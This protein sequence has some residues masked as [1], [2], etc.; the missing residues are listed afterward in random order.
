MLLVQLKSGQ[1]PTH[2][3]KILE[4]VAAGQSSEPWWAT[5]P[6]RNAAEASSAVVAEERLP[7]VHEELR[8]GTREVVRGGARV[9]TRVQE[10]PVIEELN[11]IEEFLRA[12]RRPANRLVSQEELDQ[13][14]LLRERVIEVAQFREE[15]VISKEAF[16]REEVVV[17]KTIQRRV[18]QIHET[19]R[20]T[21]VD[22]QE[23]NGDP[24]S[25]RRN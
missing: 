16:V 25:E 5:Q 19:V 12:E 17:S 6:V 11:L 2:I 3:I 9:R 21:E 1:D 18:E 24:A 8:V 14:G 22:V 10:I 13:A 20:R 4:R 7:V 23:W 15:A